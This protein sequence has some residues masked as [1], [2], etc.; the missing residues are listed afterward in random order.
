MEQSL[1]PSSSAMGRP[2][3]WGGWGGPAPLLMGTSMPSWEHPSVCI[4]GGSTGKVKLCQEGK[5]KREIFKTKLIKS[6]PDSGAGS[7]STKPICKMQRK[8][9]IFQIGER[10]EVAGEQPSL[11]SV[12]A[13]AGRLC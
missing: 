11:P 12:P 10:F 7:H 1:N 2:G 6:L 5:S 4:P 13:G 3:S 9:L 8:C